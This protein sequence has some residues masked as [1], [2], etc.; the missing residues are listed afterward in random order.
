MN[1]KDIIVFEI[2]DNPEMTSKELECLVCNNSQIATMILTHPNCTNEIENQLSEFKNN[3]ISIQIAKYTK[4]KDVIK[5]LLS[6]PDEKV[7]MKLAENE[8]L[9][10]FDMLELSKDK[11][12]KVRASLATNFNIHTVILGTLV[13]DA[14]PGVKIAAMNNP[15]RKLIVPSSQYTPESMLIDIA[16]SSKDIEILNAIATNPRCNKKILQELLN[17]NCLHNNQLDNIINI[18]IN[19]KNEELIELLLD[20]DILNA[21]HL[22][23]LVNNFINNTEVINDKLIDK[24]KHNIISNIDKI[25]YDGLEFIYKNMDLKNNKELIISLITKKEITPALI[26]NIRKA[27]INEFNNILIENYKNINPENPEVLNYLLNKEKLPLEVELD[28][29]NKIKNIEKESLSLNNKN[30]LYEEALS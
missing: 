8:N 2:K 3:K 18:I 11:S 24:I 14:D 17:N 19:N 21:T 4:Q 10:K 5:K 27:N 6:D 26:K 9:T 20:L 1:L 15:R 13:G 16:K 29:R 23:S 28:L 30:K 12:A 25:S 7:R 22:I